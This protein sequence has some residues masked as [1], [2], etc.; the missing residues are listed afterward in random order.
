MRGK[1][2]SEDPSMMGR[3][4]FPNPPMRMGMMKKNI[5]KRPWKVRREEYC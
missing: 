4:I 3:R 1:E 5:M 2:R